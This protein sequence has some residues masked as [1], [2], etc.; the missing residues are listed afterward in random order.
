MGLGLGLG[1][2]GGFF[3]AQRFQS[4]AADPRASLPFQNAPNSGSN[5]SGEVGGRQLSTGVEQGDAGAEAGNR[6]GETGPD[7]LTEEERRIVAEMKRR[8]D[9]VVRHEQAHAAVGGR[10]AGAPSYEYEQGPDGQRYAVGG[11]VSIDVSPVADDPEAT[12]TKM[13]VVKR[14]ALA[15]A[16]PSPQDYRVASLADQQ[17]LEAQSQLNQQRTEEFVEQSQ[18]GENDDAASPSALGE[19]DQPVIRNAIGAYQQ[20]GGLANLATETGRPSLLF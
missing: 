7:G 20:A 1:G 17:R 8:N 19:T 6:D 2:V 5:G 14:A 10:Y 4:E 16:E 11:E 13:E 3:P 12:I 9:E 18:G 15:P